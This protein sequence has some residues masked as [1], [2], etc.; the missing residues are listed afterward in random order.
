MDLDDLSLSVNQKQALYKIKEKLNKQYEIN[1]TLV[2]GS[3]ARKEAKPESDLDILVVTQK[4]L[5]HRE[6][7]KIYAITTEI[8]LEYDT[9]LSLLVVAANNWN[10]G[11]CSVL[12]IKKDV[13][14]QGVSF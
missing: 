3:V 6:K 4:S 9:N 2:F 13:K 5:S 11:V 8:N 7:H 10:N 12:P 14:Q 1:Q